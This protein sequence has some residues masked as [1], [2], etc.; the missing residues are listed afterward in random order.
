MVLRL[1]RRS[2]G[3]EEGAGS[4]VDRELRSKTCSMVDEM[5]CR[6]VSAVLLDLGRE[7]V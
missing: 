1:V 3:P 7:P 5:D 6:V 2:G 4:R